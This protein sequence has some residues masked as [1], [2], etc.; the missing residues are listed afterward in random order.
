MRQGVPPS[1]LFRFKGVLTTQQPTPRN[2]RVKF[3]GPARVCLRIRTQKYLQIQGGPEAENSL[4]LDKDTETIVLLKA[5][6]CGWG[7]VRAGRPP[8]G[9]VR[10]PYGKELAPET[11]SGRWGGRR[12][13]SPPQGVGLGAFTPV[14]QQGSSGALGV[15]RGDLCPAPEGAPRGGSRGGS[16]R[17]CSVPWASALSG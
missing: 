9:S 2:M 8:R 3:V 5:R 16:R 10:D 15:P 11:G 1:A 4:V 14:T 12:A 7:P 17:T 6:P 13:S